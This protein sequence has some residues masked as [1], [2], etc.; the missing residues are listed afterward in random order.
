VLESLALDPE[1]AGWQGLGFVVQAYG[2]R[3]PF[4]IDWIIDLARRAGRGERHDDEP[5]VRRIVVMLRWEVR[6]LP[7]FPSL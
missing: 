2:K 4:V 5:R 7:I 6:R 3:C 1:L